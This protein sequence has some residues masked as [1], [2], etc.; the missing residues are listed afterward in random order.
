MSAGFHLSVFDFIG[1]EA[2]QAE[3]QD[4]ALSV[5]FAPTVVSASIDLLLTCARRH[6]VGRA[7]TLLPHAVSLVASTPGWHEW[8]WALRLKQ[9][10]AEVALERGS[11][12]TAVT[13]A[14]EGIHMSRARLRRKY[15][16]LGR[17]HRRT[18][19]QTRRARE[20]I[21]DVRAGVAIARRVEDPALLLH[22]LDA[23]LGLDGNDE[24]A[25]EARALSERIAAALLDDTMR[26]RFR[27][28]EAVER[29]RRASWASS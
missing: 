17:S 29:I 3:A 26:R 15:E 1:A 5:A 9:S 2:L 7:E 12:D 24:L 8:L 28:S 21:A 10:R 18:H 20:A 6:D 4:L 11:F 23:L 16:A 19:G 22:A 27:E 14:T 13:E 25:V